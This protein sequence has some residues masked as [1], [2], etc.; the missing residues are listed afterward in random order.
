MLI[1]TFLM[2]LVSYIG[3]VGLDYIMENKFNWTDNL[4]RTV[5]LVATVQFFYWGLSS[6]K[7]RSSS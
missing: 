5:I 3:F 4:L 6:N 1:R 2:L 7:E